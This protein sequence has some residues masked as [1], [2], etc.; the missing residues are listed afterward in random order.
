MVLPAVTGYEKDGTTMNAEGRL[1]PVRAAPV[2]AGTAKD[3]TGVLKSLGEAFGTRLEGR[4]VKSARRILKKRLDVD[5]TEV[6]STGRL[7]PP[8][9]RRERTARA[10]REYVRASG[11]ALVVPSM[12]RI[13]HLDR[14]PHLRTERGDAALR[15]HPATLHAQALTSGEV[16]TIT[17]G[18][19]PRRLRIQASE[20]CPKGSG[21]YTH[22]RA[23]HS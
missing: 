2:E 14:N 7:L 4:S 13:E 15:A 11:D 8:V 16:V 22:S 21:Y 1:F 23:D 3:F 17:I 10:V 6:P 18:G 12:V 19:I 9:S 20:G 5:V